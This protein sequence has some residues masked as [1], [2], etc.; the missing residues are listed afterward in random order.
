MLSY[1]FVDGHPSTKSTKDFAVFEQ[2][3][4]WASWCDCLLKLSLGT[5]AFCLVSSLLHPYPHLFLLPTAP[6]PLFLPILHSSPIPI[7]SNSPHHPY[8][9]SPITQRQALWRKGKSS[10]SLPQPLPS[11]SLLWA[12]FFSGYPTPWKMG[13]P[14]AHPTLFTQG[15]KIRVKKAF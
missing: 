15:A 6:L 13:D 2:P 14:V 5:S 7:S 1:Y 8:P 10:T 4:G 9:P 3:L 12:G 11:Q